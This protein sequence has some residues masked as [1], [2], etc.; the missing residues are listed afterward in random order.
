[1]LVLQSKRAE[2]RLV[3]EFTILNYLMASFVFATSVCFGD[4]RDEKTIRSNALLLQF[5]FWL[6]TILTCEC[7]KGYIGHWL[8]CVINQ[9]SSL[10]TGC[11]SII[12]EIERDGFRSAFSNSRKNPTGRKVLV[13]L[14][15]NVTV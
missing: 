14:P 7:S 6:G 9:V 4:L 5:L 3:T 8:S 15:N 12:Q 1:M 13:I 10:W 2:E 11:W